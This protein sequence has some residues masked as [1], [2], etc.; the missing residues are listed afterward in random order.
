MKSTNFMKFLMQICGKASALPK[1]GLSAFLTG[2]HK[3]KND[4]FRVSIRCP[5][6]F[7]GFFPTLFIY[8]DLFD[9][10]PKFR[11]FPNVQKIVQGLFMAESSGA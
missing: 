4:A 7:S 5:D 2:G 10:S 9:F 8:W 11:E 6:Y 1:I 3:S